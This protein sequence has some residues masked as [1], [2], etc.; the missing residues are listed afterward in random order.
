MIDWWSVVTNS[1]WI[2]GLAV[3]H[4]AFSYSY[5]LGGQEGTTLR[6][7]LEKPTFLRVFAIALVLVGIGLAG[8]SQTIWETALSVVL[9]ISSVVF[10][11]TLRNK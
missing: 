8:T 11:F 3:L 5:W 2:L 10:F 7:Q 9:I 4:A 6:Q 1:F